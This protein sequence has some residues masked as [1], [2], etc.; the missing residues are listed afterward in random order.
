MLV[1]VGVVF[2]CV[3]LDQLHHSSA[4]IKFKYEIIDNCNISDQ[5]LALARRVAGRSV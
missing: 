4:V 5:Q 1:D 3:P 2:T